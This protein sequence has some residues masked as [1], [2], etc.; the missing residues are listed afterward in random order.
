MFVFTVCLVLTAISVE[1]EVI[2]G[3]PNLYNNYHGEYAATYDNYEPRPYAFEYGVSDPHTGDHKTQWETKDK[4][5][6][7]RGSYSLLEP[8]GS[9]RIVDYI[10][11]DHGFRAIVKKIGIHGQ[12]VESHGGAV[13]QGGFQ[14]IVVPDFEPVPVHVEQPLHV[15]QPIHVEQPLHVEQP[16]HLPPVQI[17]QAPIFQSYDGG[18]EHYQNLIQHQQ[19][20]PLQVPKA[21]GIYVETPKHDFG[22][23][24]PYVPQQ[25]LKQ[26]SYVQPLPAVPKQDVY[27]QQPQV[28]PTPAA[29]SGEVYYTQ[30][31]DFGSPQAKSVVTFQQPQVVPQEKIAEP[32]NV[33]QNVVYQQNQ[34][35]YPVQKLIEPYQNLIPSHSYQLEQHFPGDNQVLLQN[36]VPAY[37][38]GEVP[39][40]IQQNILHP[41]SESSQNFQGT[42]GNL[43]DDSQYTNYAQDN[44]AQVVLNKGET[45]SPATKY[46]G[47]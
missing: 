26:D 21:E 40:A 4:A 23:Y 8:D 20:Y 22:G 17:E 27:L 5:G 28:A 42:T 29:P 44:N 33:E 16:I 19:P 47:W 30:V 18:V 15:E 41:Y 24:V 45:L 1:A 2:L 12:S 10:A 11:D 31:T 7:V 3:L 43:E 34:Q 46:G 32:V 9:T 6:V 35:Q 36:Q 13:E 14:P 38:Q 39:Y 37:G 25:Y